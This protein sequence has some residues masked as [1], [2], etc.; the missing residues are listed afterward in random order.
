M[1]LISNHEL[2]QAAAALA[3]IVKHGDMDELRICVAEARREATRGA[4]AP[5]QLTPGEQIEVSHLGTLLANLVGLPQRVCE[6]AARDAICGTPTMAAM[7]E[8]LRYARQL[9][10]GLNRREAV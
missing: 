6:Q 7:Q 8:I 10:D 5:W 4:A 9:R 2:R 3:Y 1:N